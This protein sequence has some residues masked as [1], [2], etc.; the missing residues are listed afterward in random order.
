M[1]RIY[2]LSMVLTA[3]VA[4]SLFSSVELS[5]RARPTNH[6]DIT[7]KGVRAIVIE[8]FE[9]A[10]V[11]A[12]LD[13]DGWFVRTTPSP[14]NSE[15][16]EQKLRQKNPVPALE[17][18]MI[19]GAPRDLEVEPWS[20][21]G[22][23]LKKEKL[24]GVYFRFR[25]PGYNSVHLVAPKE[26]DWRTREPFLRPDPATGTLAQERGI[27]LPGRAKAIS[28]WVQGRGYAYNLEAWV[29][30]YR[31]NTHVLHLGSIDFMG[32][33]P[34]MVRIPFSVPTPPK[35]MPQVN[36]TRLTELVIRSQINSPSVLEM[37]SDT[38][39]FFDQIKVLT[40]DY[41][42]FFDGLDLYKEFETQ[43]QDK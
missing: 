13:S 10:Q 8:D 35:A 7:S 27:Q 32:W 40:D 34:M 14:F 5:S 19:E 15:E 37:M 18:K 36:V 43:T 17:L 9:E 22:L 3:V 23:G 16:T 4:F 31:G 12:D 1:K 39:V 28:V 25:Y 24:M 2:T 21:T 30:D 29:K 42:A 11:A 38:Y 41:E 20:P 26:V 6:A 33:K